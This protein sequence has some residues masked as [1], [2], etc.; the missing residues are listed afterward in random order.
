M[1]SL[2]QRARDLM[3]NISPNPGANLDLLLARC[4]PVAREP[5]IVAWVVEQAF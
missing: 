4:E 3:P 5:C 1:A 2:I